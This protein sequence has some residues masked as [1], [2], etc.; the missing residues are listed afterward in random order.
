MT[1]LGQQVSGR[2]PHAFEML[3]D[4]GAL[5]QPASRLVLGTTKHSTQIFSECL[6]PVFGGG[7]G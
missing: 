1:E 3:D 5:I 7:H 4:R 2:V 6:D